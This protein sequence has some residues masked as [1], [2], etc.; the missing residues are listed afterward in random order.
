MQLQHAQFIK[1]RIERETLF[2]TAAIFAASLLWIN[3]SLYT[4]RAETPPIT[5]EA[6]AAAPVAV[7]PQEVVPI[8]IKKVPLQEVHI[9]NNGMALL[10]GVRVKSLGTDTLTVETLWESGNFT[11]NIE[12]Y[13]FTKFLNSKGE[14]SE[15]KEIH[16]G[17][18]V[19]IN[20]ILTNGGGSPALKADFIRIY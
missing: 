20:G 9:A 11:W 13:Q 16:E 14:P 15:W 5:R 7:G 8:P 10:R 2:V 1:P 4:V 6:V 18:T 12:T 3:F 17:D 19:T